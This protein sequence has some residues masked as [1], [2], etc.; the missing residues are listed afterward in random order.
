[1]TLLPA[2]LRPVSVLCRVVGNFNQ[3]TSCASCSNN[4][5][6]RELLLRSR[7][8][9]Y[10]LIIKMSTNLLGLYNKLR[11]EILVAFWSP[12]LLYTSDVIEDLGFIA[13]NPQVHVLFNDQAVPNIPQSS[14]DAA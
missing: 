6:S 12:R 3:H 11:L 7:S 13:C 8:A 10:V 2:R 5:L 1:M 4:Q 14:N 9:T